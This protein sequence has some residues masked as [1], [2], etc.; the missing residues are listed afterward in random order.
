MILKFEMPEQ[1]S[2]N[3]D[4]PIFPGCMVTVAGT[5]P[6]CLLATRSGSITTLTFIRRLIIN[7]QFYKGVYKCNPGLARTLM[8]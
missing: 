4:C 7:I 5:K 6:D 3:Q 1:S 8:D 2:K